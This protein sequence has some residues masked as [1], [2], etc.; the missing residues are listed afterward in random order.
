MTTKAE[1]LKAVRAKCL[2]CSN[3]QPS[4]VQLCVI[5]RC[6]L[7]P[8]RMGSDPTP[9]PTKVAQGKNLQPV[10]AENTEDA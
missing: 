6:A 4:E 3:Y 9:N 7:Y 1:L 2:D 10:V 5:P 8:Y